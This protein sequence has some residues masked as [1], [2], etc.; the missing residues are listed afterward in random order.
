MMRLRHVAGL[1]SEL[2]AYSVVNRSVMPALFILLVLLTA[3]I[4]TAATVATPYLYT[5]F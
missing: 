4:T 3:L 5:I 1:L 2:A